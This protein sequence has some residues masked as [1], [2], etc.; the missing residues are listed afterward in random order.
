MNA[1]FNLLAALL[2]AS[3]AT[4]AQAATF[5][6]TGTQAYT[7][8]AVTDSIASGGLGAVLTQNPSPPT[9][10]GSWTIDLMTGQLANGF[11]FDP[12]SISVDMSASGFGVVSVTVPD[13]QLQLVGGIYSYDVATRTI[14]ITGGIFQESSPSVMCDDGGTGFCVA[15]PGPSSP[16]HGSLTLTFAAD[17]QSF[18][19]VAHV[20]QNIDL[21]AMDTTGICLAEGGM[22]P[23]A[24]N[25]LTF[26][27][28]TELAAVPVPAA[29]WLFGSAALGL[30]GL[31]RRKA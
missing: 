3:A 9:F 4:T 24:N 17:M 2:V 19:G 30:A 23:C 13:R 6:V 31:K 22:N 16:S 11:N 14:A 15:V 18:T 27:G 7:I 29:A 25:V 21:L 20:Y 8:D 1:K 10:S 5:A 26:S 28:A 12:Y